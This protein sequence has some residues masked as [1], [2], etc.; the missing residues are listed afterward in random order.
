[1]TIPI[2]FAIDNNVVMPC[3]VTITS[4]LKNAKADTFYDIYVLCNQSK[5]DVDG[6]KKLN[7]AFANSSQCR[8]TF[9]DVSLDEDFKETDWQ[10]T[11]HLTTAAFYRLAIPL[12]FPQFGKVIY[13]DVDMIFQQDLSELFVNSLQ[14]QELIAAVLDLAIDDKY[15]F[16]SKLPSMIGKSVKDYFNSGFLVMN[17]KQMRE[18]NIVEQFNEHAKIKYDQNDQDVLNVVCSGRVQI[19]PILYN[20]QM[21]HFASYMWGRTSTDILFGELFK[22]ATLHYTGKFKPWNSLECVASD[23]WWHYYK[24]SPFYDDMVY[25]MRQYDLIE[26]HKND[27]RVKS[28]IQLLTR[29]MVNIKHK[30][31]G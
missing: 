26:S 9:V 31:F 7:D 15:Y 8:I 19:L 3:G 30:L 1:M 21:N 12:L 23:T 25:F 10:T 22:Y 11:G 27:Y 18:E 29:V 14:Q 28:N 6:R 17:L 20:F 2:I 4:L 16:Q 5:L 13:A 24:M